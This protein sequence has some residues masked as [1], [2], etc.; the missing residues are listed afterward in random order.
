VL[1]KWL[2][3]KEEHPR[4]ANIRGRRIGS[5]RCLRWQAARSATNRNFPTGFAETAD[6]MTADLQTP[7]RLR[8]KRNNIEKGLI[9][10]LFSSI[11]FWKIKKFLKRNPQ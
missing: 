5:F 4:P 9:R 11:F 2:Y 3:Q 10:A 6:T 8:I 1:N 7:P